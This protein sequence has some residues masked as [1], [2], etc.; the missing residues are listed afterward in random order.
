M[1]KWDVTTDDF[2]GSSLS[3]LWN[4]DFGGVTVSG[5]KLRCPSGSYS[6][7]DTVGHDL[8]SSS[9]LI[10]VEALATGYC[11]FMLRDEATSDFIC[12][13]NYS[14]TGSGTLTGRY[15]GSNW[16]SSDVASTTNLG[17]GARTIWL[18]FRHNGT[19]LFIEY[20]SDGSSW[21]TLRSDA[22]ASSI[23]DDCEVYLD[24]GPDPGGSSG[25]VQ[26][27]KLNLP[28]TGAVALDGSAAGATSTSAALG[29]AQA[30]SGRAEGGQGGNKAM[31]LTGTQY[32]VW[33]VAGIAVATDISFGCWFKPATAGAS[34]AVMAF[35]TGAGGNGPEVFWRNAPDQRFTLFYT[36][37]DTFSHESVGPRALEEWYHVLYTLTAAGVATLYINGVQTQTASGVTAINSPVNAY[38]L[39]WGQEFDGASPSNQV[40]GRIDEGMLFTRILNS[41]ERAALANRFMGETAWAAAVAAMSPF[42]WWR[43]NDAIGSTTMADS[44]G[45][46]RNGTYVGGPWLDAQGA[47][48]PSPPAEMLIMRLLDGSASGS[49]S[50]SAEMGFAVPLDGSAAGALTATGELSV[51]IGLSGTAGGSTATAPAEMHAELALAGQ[52]DGATSTSAEMGR[53]L[54]ITGSAA[55]ATSTTATLT[56]TKGQMELVNGGA[57]RNWEAQSAPPRMDVHKNG[58]RSWEVAQ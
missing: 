12:E 8:S 29:V 34:Q 42:A 32:G 5:N 47:I 28:P 4:G 20:S 10:K 38:T 46:G 14:G 16:G 54:G 19:T 55:G 41:S 17:A 39:S 33:T 1:A 44:S 45:N 37:P 22:V 2:P 13:L 18:R 40:T 21:S 49:T 11:G 7:A 24:V 6:G 51:G 53:G 3:G 23:V 57:R 48:D 52:A 9:C 26:W 35:N 43:M 31:A 56:V 15:Y 30:L 36:N 58:R 25:N 27:S 50:T